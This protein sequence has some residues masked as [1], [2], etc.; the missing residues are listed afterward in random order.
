MSRNRPLA[1]A[2]T[3]AIT[4]SLAGKCV[5]VNAAEKGHFWGNWPKPRRDQEGQRTTGRLDLDAPQGMMTEYSA[6]FYL[7]MIEVMC[8]I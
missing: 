6:V 5:D 4:A 2:P 1:A 8:N 7:A 3:D